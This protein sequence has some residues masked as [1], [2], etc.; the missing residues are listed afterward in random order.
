M[1]T[2][3]SGRLR[4]DLSVDQAFGSREYAVDQAKVGKCSLSITLI[5]CKLT[6]DIDSKGNKFRL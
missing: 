3:L 4:N 5:F 1:P 6:L 2:G